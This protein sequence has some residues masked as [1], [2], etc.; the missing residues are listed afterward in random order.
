[1][2]VAKRRADGHKSLPLPCDVRVADPY[3]EDVRPKQEVAG[4][5]GRA[6]V[7]QVMAVALM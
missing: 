1:M 6:A 2:R 7:Q 3:G 4:E 5:V